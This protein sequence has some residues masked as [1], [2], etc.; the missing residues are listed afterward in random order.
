MLDKVVTK[1]AS[2]PRLVTFKPR[3]AQFHMGVALDAAFVVPWHFLPSSAHRDLVQP[4]LAHG[5]YGYELEPDTLIGIAV[6]TRKRQAA[7]GIWNVRPVCYLDW[8]SLCGQRHWYRPAVS[9]SRCF[10]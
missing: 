2:L 7:C 6:E 10:L 5:T 8:H 4:T 9:A 3:G 1:L